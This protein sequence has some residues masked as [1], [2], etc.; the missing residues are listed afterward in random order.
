MSVVPGLRSPYDQVGGIVHFG[1]MLDKIRLM[2]KGE[3]PP[4]YIESA[5]VEHGGFDARCVRFLK[6]DYEKLK[7][8]VLE[9][10]AD[11]EVLQWAFET[12]RK[13]THDEIEM[14]NGFMTRRGWRDKTRARVIFRCEEAGISADGVETMFDFIDIDEGRPQRKFVME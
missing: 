4:D 7:Q 10:G 13:P 2:A 6:L 3:L 14:W 9:G 1:R 12:G 11:D 5:G 8:Q